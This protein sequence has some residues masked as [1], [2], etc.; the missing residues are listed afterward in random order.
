MGN[1]D[2]SNIVQYFDKVYGVNE[3]KV[4]A[5][6]YH[7][8]MTH[9]PMIESELYRWD[10]NMHGHLHENKINNA[11]YINVCA[12]H[13]NFTPQAIDDVVET[14]VEKH[15]ELKINFPLK[16]RR[17]VTDRPNDF[18]EWREPPEEP[19]LSLI[20]AVPEK[21]TETRIRWH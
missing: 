17:V 20:N 11:R 2:D 1:H 3:V 13:M 10:F 21:L 5:K 16:W 7:V 14:H 9:I 8:V 19:Y 4:C 15:V 12:E 6:K 18:E